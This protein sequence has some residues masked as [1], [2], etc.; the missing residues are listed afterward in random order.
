MIKLAVCSDIHLNFLNTDKVTQFAE[1]IFK[2]G[3][4]AVL[5]TGDLSEGDKLIV[6]LSIMLAVVDKPIYFVLGNHDYWHSSF[7][8]VQDALKALMT[9]EKRLV[10]LQGAD[11][12][13][14]TGKTALTGV[15]GWY[16]AGWG[17]WKKGGIFMNDWLKIEE[18]SAGTYMMPYGGMSHDR[19]SYISTSRKKAAE[20]TQIG[21][22]LL[23]KAFAVRDHVIFATHVPPFTEVAKYRGRP[24]DTDALPYYT[25]RTMGNMLEEYAKSLPIEKSLTV[26]CGHTHDKAKHRVSHNLTVYCS[27]AEYGRPGISEMVNVL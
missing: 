10:W 2:A 13:L 8:K 25:S 18:F 6:H 4:D 23:D 27:P 7:K 9:A 19:G 16:D 14:L 15:D 24:T 20:D 12:V 17:D 21:K 3:P 26:F 5:V 1:K 22:E 11:P